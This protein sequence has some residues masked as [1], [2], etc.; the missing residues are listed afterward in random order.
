MNLIK[1]IM[2]NSLWYKQTKH[3]SKPVGVLWHDTGAGNPN[4]KR[5]VQPMEGD[6]N[7]NEM[8]RIL[9]KNSNANDWNHAQVEKGVNAI[10]GKLANG[11]VGTVQTGE[12]EMA[13]WGCYYGT[14]GS[15]NGYVKVAGKTVYQGKHW[16]QVEIADD[17][18]KDKNYFNKVYKEACEL[19]AYLCKK[20]GI[21]PYGTVNFNGV[22]VPTILCHQD[23]YQLKLGSNHAD[24]YGWFK[25]MGMVQNM[26][27][28]RA[29][30]AA[31]MGITKEENNMSAFNLGDEVKIRPEATTYY[32]GANMPQWIKNSTLYVRA[33]KPENKVVISTQKTGAVTGTV[34]EKDLILVSGATPEVKEEPVV[35]NPTVKVEIPKGKTPKVEITRV[36]IPKSEIPKTEVKE[37]AKVEASVIKKEPKKEET[38]TS[39]IDFLRELLD[40]ILETLQK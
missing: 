29:D 15:C 9:G 38:K 8:I 27:K 34:F 21:D 30:V 16:I 3:D 17:F 19:T 28:T 39:F 18:Y 40:T 35:K 14:K 2:T 25:A 1:C 20:Y 22:T 33:F 31:L 11:S 37:E 4:V 12:W 13:P 5:Y 26:D 7:Y 23:A 24:I 10:I 6:A 36:E 32:N